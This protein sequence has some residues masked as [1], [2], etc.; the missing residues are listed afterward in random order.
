M[1]QWFVPHAVPEIRMRNSEF[2]R[3]YTVLYRIRNIGWVTYGTKN[4]A[5]ETQI[6]VGCT[7][8]ATYTW[9]DY[10]FACDTYVTHTIPTEYTRCVVHTGCRNYDFGNLS[11]IVLGTTGATR[12][13]WC[14]ALHVM[15]TLWS[16]IHNSAEYMFSK[17]NHHCVVHT[18]NDVHS[19]EC[20]THQ[21]RNE[22]WCNG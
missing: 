11:T 5:C 9:H 4:N 16:A 22:H 3:P 6:V 14:S 8:F 18:W 13:L 19:V 12:F 15:C 21:C 17:W 1:G 20:F 2:R 10:C 7:W